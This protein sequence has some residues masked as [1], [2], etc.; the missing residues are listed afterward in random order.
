[1]RD[2]NARVCLFVRVRGVQCMLGLR[3]PH[4]YVYNR[5]HADAVRALSMVVGRHLQTLTFSA[6]RREKDRGATFAASKT[7]FNTTSGFVPVIR[8]P[9][10]PSQEQD[11]T[12]ESASLALGIHRCDAECD[13][14][15]LAVGVK[16]PAGYPVSSTGNSLLSRLQAESIPRSGRKAH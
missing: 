13:R 2:A 14:W 8:H 7:L 15:R 4:A 10:L 1:M 16:R 12:L 6:L 9:A 11:A 3:L 5:S